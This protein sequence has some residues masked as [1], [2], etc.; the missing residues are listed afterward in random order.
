MT[1]SPSRVISETSISGKRALRRDTEKHSINRKGER[2]VISPELA[3]AALAIFGTLFGVWLGSFLARGNED[4]QWRRDRCLE[5]YTDLLRACDIVADEV[6]EA[7]ETKRGSLKHATQNGLIANKVGEMYRL[8]DRV[9]LLGSDGIQ[10]PL[11]ALTLHCGQ[12]VA[13]AKADQNKADQKMSDD[14]MQKAK[15]TGYVSVYKEFRNAARNDLALHTV[16]E[17]KNIFRKSK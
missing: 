12:L 16:H 9:A 15:F 10:E 2:P 5:A 8:S 13:T 11:S 7:R 14:E 1:P 4:R 6:S 17:W 3:L